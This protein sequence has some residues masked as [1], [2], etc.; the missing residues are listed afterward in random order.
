V[1]RA[2]LLRIVKRAALLVGAVAIT[3]VVVRIWDTRRGPE[4]E[5]WHTHAPVE[6]RA[7]SRSGRGRTA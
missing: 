2:R 3:L 6:R 4:L 7:A 5:L 1:V